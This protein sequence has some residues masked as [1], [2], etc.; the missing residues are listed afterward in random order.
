LSTDRGIEDKGFHITNEGSPMIRIY[1]NFDINRKDTHPVTLIK[2]GTSKID[3]INTEFE[4]I[5]RS[6]FL[7][8]I[9]FNGVEKKQEFTIIK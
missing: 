9:W 3:T 6:V 7:R 8:K 2:F 4:Y 1:L 5:G